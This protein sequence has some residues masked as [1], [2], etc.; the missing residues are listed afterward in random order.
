MT[1]FDLNAM[2]DHRRQV[3]HG[4]LIRPSYIRNSLFA[5]FHLPCVLSILERG[6][7]IKQI[8]QANKCL[9]IF[10]LFARIRRIASFLAI[11]TIRAQTAKFLSAVKSCPLILRWFCISHAWLPHNLS[12]KKS[13]PGTSGRFFFWKDFEEPMREK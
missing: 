2:S 13:R 9:V 3:Q 7:Y 6:E 1:T 4:P 10:V 12:I 11:T 5:S 8:I